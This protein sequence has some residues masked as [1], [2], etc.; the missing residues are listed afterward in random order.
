MECTK[1]NTTQG[2]SFDVAL[3]SKCR[4]RCLCT[5]VKQNE[6]RVLRIVFLRR[7]PHDQIAYARIYFTGSTMF[8]RKLKLY[9]LQQNLQLG[10]TI[11]VIRWFLPPALTSG[12]VY[13]QCVRARPYDICGRSHGHFVQESRIWT[14]VCLFVF[15]SA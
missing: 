8:L 7:Y 5:I 4:C 10:P 9:A 13:V 1:R 2:I 15:D 14:Q 12:P 6:T 11:R 3:I